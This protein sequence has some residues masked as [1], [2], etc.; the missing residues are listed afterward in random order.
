MEF[1]ISSKSDNISIP[2]IFYMHD[3]NTNTMH[4]L[5]SFSVERDLGVQISLNIKFDAQIK[6]CAARANMILSKLKKTFTLV[7][8]YFQ[9]SLNSLCT[10][11]FRVFCP[12][13]VSI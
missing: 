11:T 13:L 12:S 5:S 2:F 8:K 7:D 6:Q 1:S 4:T 9:I 10:T 3:Y